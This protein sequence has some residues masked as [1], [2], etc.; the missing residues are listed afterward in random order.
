[1]TQSLTPVPDPPADEGSALDLRPDGRVTIW[2]NDDTDVT[3]RRPTLGQ[4][5]AWRIALNEIASETGRMAQASA[6]AAVAEQTDDDLAAE[7]K[8][9]RRSARAVAVQE[10]AEGGAVTWW[11]DVFKALAESEVPSVDDWPPWLVLSN[12]VLND[13]LT[14]WRQVPL[15]P[16][17]RSNKPNAPKR[18]S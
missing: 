17:T 6:E 3:L 10:A 8:L 5:K 15:A 2:F 4:F 7:E 18:R 11:T 9:A 16:G 12:T 1:M 13:V 14:H